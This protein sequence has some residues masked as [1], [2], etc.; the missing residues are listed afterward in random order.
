MSSTEYINISD[1]KKPFHPKSKVLICNCYICDQC[2]GEYAIAYLM[3][4]IQS[5][6]G[7]AI[8]NQGGRKA[9]IPRPYFSIILE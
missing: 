7:T 1:A 2:S 5:C 6:Y 4:R 3:V 8:G 9:N